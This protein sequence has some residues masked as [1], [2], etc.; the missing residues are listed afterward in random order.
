LL[1]KK[2]SLGEVYNFEKERR[3]LLLEI[4][5]FK[6]KSLLTKFENERKKREAIFK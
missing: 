1:N 4:G 5:G 6:N 3:Q 2:K